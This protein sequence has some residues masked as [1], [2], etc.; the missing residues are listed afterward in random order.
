MK[1]SSFNILQ[2]VSG[3]HGYLSILS[4]M[5][6]AGR[7]SSRQETVYCSECSL[8]IEGKLSKLTPLLLTGK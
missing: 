4:L 5:F 8:H 1:H 7:G 2:W 6:G 3:F